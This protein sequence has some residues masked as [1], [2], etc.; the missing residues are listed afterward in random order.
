M[1][2]GDNVDAARRLSGDFKDS[3]V[4]HAWD[5]DRV[6]AER[7][8][9]S[10]NLKKTPW[11]IYL[12]YGPGTRW[13]GGSLPSPSRW[14][15]QLPSEYGIDESALLDPGTLAQEALRLLGREDGVPPVDRKLRF[16]ARGV[17]ETQRKGDTY[18]TFM[19]EVTAP[20][21]PQEC[22]DSCA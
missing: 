22:D 14:M 1:M 16:H 19:Q 9:K 13:E 15:A 3:R 12:L 18:R 2:K 8:G 4:F 7:V 5:P 6:F 10:L 21:S 17:L 20:A 11:D